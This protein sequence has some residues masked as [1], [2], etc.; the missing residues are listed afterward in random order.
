MRI[1]RC[2]GAPDP[3]LPATIR[4]RKGSDATART[5]NALAEGYESAR[6]RPDSLDVLIEFPAQLSL[7]GEVAGK[8]V[9]DLACG[10]G[11]KALYLARQGAREVVGVDLSET[12]MQGLARQE[13][14]SNTRFLQGDISRLDQVQGLAGL[15][16]VVL[17]LNALSY[18]E[19]EAATL[20]DIRR[21]MSADGIL[22]LARA[23]PFRFAVERGEATGAE[24]GAAY[25]DRS[26]FSYSSTWEPGVIVTHRTATFGD[27]V[28]GLVDAGFWIDRVVEPTLSE[29]QRRQFPH[30]QAWLERYT[31]TLIV[32]ARPR[33]RG[34]H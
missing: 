27:T 20:R 13:L 22:V 29:E 21:L 10:S 19:D 34:D 23:H 24:V 32:R 25:H 12:F 7:I 8:R 31:G 3:L 30:K 4:G 9:L 16:D 17:L 2:P 11:A 26:P 28:N 14:P 1:L 33:P 18:A 6:T 5:W 15:F